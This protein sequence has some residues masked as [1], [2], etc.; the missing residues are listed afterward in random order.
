L[1]TLNIRADLASGEPAI[2]LPNLPPLPPLPSAQTRNRNVIAFSLFGGNSKYCE[3]AVLNVQEQSSIYP[4]WVCRFYIDDSVPE[5]V[6]NRLQSG[7]AQIVRVEGAA[8]QWPGQ[9]WR[10]LVLNDPQAHRILFRDADSLI[11]RREAAAVSQWLNS[12]KRFHIMR[13]DGGHTE[14]ILA[15]LWGAVS[16]SLPP[17]DKLMENFMSA[18][19]NSQHFADQDFLRQYVWPYAKDNM[20]QHDSV[21]GFMNAASFPDGERPDV[22]HVGCVESSPFFTAKCN[23]P[24]GSEVTWALYWIIK[25][26]DDGQI[27]GELV[28]SYPGKV[29]EGA[30]RAQIPARY[31]RWLQQGTAC[32][33]II[34]PPEL[35]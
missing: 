19:L 24:D 25:K 6:I 13:D 31:A 28:C 16:G 1:Q 35:T 27:R 20:M 30:V 12:G 29:Y 8:R 34:M 32:I 7:G 18:P 5:S 11:S 22:S 17:L 4:H 21:F 15:G 26:H 23:L 10:L 3:P 14:L 33:R 2:P 9:M